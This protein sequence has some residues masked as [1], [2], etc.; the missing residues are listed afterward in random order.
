MTLSKGSKR[1]HRMA[2]TLL[3]KDVMTKGVRGVGP[4][5]SVIIHSAGHGHPIPD[6]GAGEK[7]AI[8]TQPRAKNMWR[9]FFSL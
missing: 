7:R 8:G 3:V 6:Q 9:G 4:D 2:D 5:S 1:K